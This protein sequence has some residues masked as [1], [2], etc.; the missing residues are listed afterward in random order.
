M[1]LSRPAVIELV[2]PA[3]VG[4]TTLSL[5]LQTTGHARR[6]TMWFVPRPALLRSAIR[7]IPTALTLYRQT[8]R[9]LWSEIKHL[10]RL[11]ALH[12]AVRTTHRN[13]TALIA[14]D[15]GPVYTLSWLQVIGHRRF[16]DG[17][18]LAFLQRTLERW[19]PQ[20]D[21]VIVLDAPDPIITSRIREREKP[22]L[23]K[24]R[25]SAE[26]A[27]FLAAYRRATERVLA[28][29][30]AAGGPPVVRIDCSDDTNRLTERVLEAV[31][32][33]AH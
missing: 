19:V 23:V 4:K 6:G 14:L 25:S 2:G 18:P 29:L 22:H 5:R 31:S 17:P 11:D 24:D 1:G 12:T 28:D 27:A 32:V 33:H 7:Q 9:F 21:A 10:I 8:G 30:H 15:E 26:I 20:L 16:C 3:G 13:G